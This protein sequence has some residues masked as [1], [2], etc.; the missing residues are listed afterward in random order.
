MTQIP[1]DLGVSDWIE[2]TQDDVRAF[3]MITRSS[4]RIHDDPEWAAAN[5]PF[6]GT[7][8]HGFQTL[9][10]LT[11][12]LSDV[13]PWRSQ[14]AKDGKGAKISVNY[15]FDKVRYIAPVKVG[16]RVRGRFALI[17]IENAGPGRTLSR[18]SCT[19]E[20]EGEDKPALVAEWLG[21]VIEGPAQ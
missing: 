11:A 8:A 6:G 10:L 19:V 20:I 21:L 2:I 4:E 13:R 1:T 14:D 16:A 18:M 5:T 12:F 15:G 3:G 9:S 7:I 17:G